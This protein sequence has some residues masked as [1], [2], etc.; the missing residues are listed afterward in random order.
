MIVSDNIHGVNIVNYALRVIRVSRAPLRS[1][2][3]IYRSKI[4]FFKLH[5]E[6]DD[7]IHTMRDNIFYG[8][9]C[10]SDIS[11]INSILAVAMARFLILPRSWF[12]F[13]SHSVSKRLYATTVKNILKFV[14]FL[15]QIKKEKMHVH[16]PWIWAQLKLFSFLVYNVSSTYFIFF[17]VFLETCG[18]LIAFWAFV[19]L[20]K[21]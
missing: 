19:T 14:V 7:C 18:C 3:F 5:F 17:S 2:S 1:I 12:A 16:K 11:V 20:D 9:N 8:L 15:S 4:F 10:L 6:T 13:N 21:Q